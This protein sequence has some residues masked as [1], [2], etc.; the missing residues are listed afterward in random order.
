MKSEWKILGVLFLSFTLGVGCGST[1]TTSSATS[2]G[3]TTDTTTSKAVPSDVVLSSPTASTSASSSISNRLLVKQSEVGDATTDDFSAKRTA[4]RN[5]IAGDNECKFTLSIPTVSNVSCYG[6][7]VNYQGHPNASGGE[8]PSG[9]MPIGDTGIWNETEGTQACAAAKMNELVEKV[10]SKI[11]NMISIF[12]A[13]ACAGKKA[14]V[15][16][17]AVGASVDLSSALSTHVKTTGLSF[18]NATL[19][20]LAD[21]ASGNQVYRS[22]LTMS[23]TFP[24]A[25]GTQTGKITLT[26]IPTAADN[27][28]Y[29]GVVSMSMAV[30]QTQGGNCNQINQAAG[31][32]GGVQAASILYEKTSATAMTYQV[33]YADFCGSNTDP[34][35]SSAY[36][37]FS[38][39][40]SAT[41][42]DGWA[43]NGN[44][45]VATINPTDGT[46]TV[47]YAWQ[48]G[49]NDNN[50]RV[51][52]IT[53]STNSSTSVTTGTAYA[54]FGPDIAATS[55]LGTI[56][57][58]ICNWAGP[59]NNHT[60]ATKAQRQELSRASGASVF[61]ATT[62]NIRY[63][64]QNSCD[65]AAADSFLY[66][67]VNGGNFQ[68]VNGANPNV[69]SYSNNRQA[70][71]T[72]L[73]NELIDMT[74]V[75]FTL[76]TAPSQI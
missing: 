8:Q 22:T 61:T 48:A 32:S 23:M 17:P 42:P 14:S 39:K 20:R 5:L 46:G 13:M 33:K 52:D 34:F 50:T 2:S 36:V 72:A 44:Y 15:A 54:G 7:T 11:D 73:T 63:A 12:G 45:M 40:A 29:K 9:Q 10:A 43:D 53:T 21:D 68:G 26:H 70:A 24:G 28:T 3:Q 56:D 16:L 62:S 18:S 57:R 75:S 1:S 37:A 35:A 41:N 4:L 60:G 65:A 64:P 38:D 25:G 71:T 74:A 67:A 49:A 51:F 6:P 58:F 30:S 47:A 55:G 59:G 76:P 66:E 69:L 19:A 31:Q 27:S